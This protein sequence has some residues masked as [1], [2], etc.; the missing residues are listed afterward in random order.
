M[1]TSVVK[2]SLKLLKAIDKPLKVPLCSSYCYRL[3]HLNYSYVA[4]YVFQVSCTV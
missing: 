2:C 4:S 3:D 1:Q